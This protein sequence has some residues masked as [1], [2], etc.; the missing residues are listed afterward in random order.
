M[1][2]Y[3]SDPIQY[4]IGECQRDPAGIRHRDVKK[5]FDTEIGSPHP[6]ILAA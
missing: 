3:V 5:V 4:V 6:P 2:L 1:V